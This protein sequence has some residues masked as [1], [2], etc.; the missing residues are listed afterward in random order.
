MRDALECDD[1]IAHRRF[2]YARDAA[3]DG[4]H[5]AAAD[6]LEQTLE[7]A[8]EWAAAWFALGEA[9]EKLGDA[10][11][12]AAAFGAAL[13]LDANDPQG[14][15][16]RLALI[17]KRDPSALPPAYIARLFDEYSP[18]FD[19]HLTG[20]LAYRG[21]EL[22]VAALARVAPARK[23][24]RALDLGCGTGLVGAALEGRVNRLAGVDLSVKMVAKARESGRY[25]A[26]QVGDAVAFLDACTQSA[27]L[28]VA[29]DVLVYF[30]DLN[31][32]FAGIKRALA[33]GGLFAFSVEASEDGDYWLRPTLRFAHSERY[34]RE[35]A[36]QAGFSPL[37][38][39]AAATRR[40]AGADVPGWIAVFQG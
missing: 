4:D 3:E 5:A 30:G 2:A 19:A 18:R 14:A 15:G 1:P 37:V 23:F 16:A 13:R 17:E 22:L 21:P 40:E 24:A 7:L 8:P 32:V 39:Q 11:A 10:E 33:S 12:A 20:E 31:P 27:D 36:A 25:E 29:A 28:I 6:V 34:L 38:M 9:R 26:L 35:A